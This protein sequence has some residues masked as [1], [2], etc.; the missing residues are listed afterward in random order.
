MILPLYVC[1]NNLG[2]R[3]TKLAF[4]TIITKVVHRRVH[5]IIAIVR[6][7]DMHSNIIITLFRKGQRSYYDIL[8][9]PTYLLHSYKCAYILICTYF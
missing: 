7:Q 2:E 4:L 1:T 9:N 3:W 6:T 8:D 5:T